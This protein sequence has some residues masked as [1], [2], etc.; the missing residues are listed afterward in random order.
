LVEVIHIFVVV[1]GASL[2]KFGFCM[3]DRFL[4]LQLF[5]RVARTGS[6]SIAGREMGMSQPTASRIVATLEKKVGVALLTRTTRG[7]TLTEA[8]SDY[9]VRAEAILAAL[10]EADHAARGTGELRGVLRVA[11][12]TSTAVR[13]ALPRLSRFTDLHPNLRIEFVL[14]DEKQDLVGDGIDVALRIGS[15]ADSSAIARKVGVVYRTLAAAPAYLAKAGT[16]RVPSDLANHSVIVGPAGRGMEGWAFKKDGKASSVRV[17]GRFVL[18]AA[19]G[20]TAAAVAGLGI[21]SNGALGM[22]KELES[23]LLVRV[24]PDWEMGTAEAHVILAAGHAAK[25]S[26]KAFSDFASSQFRELEA[27]WDRIKRLAPIPATSLAVD[28][29]AAVG[30]DSQGTA[31][32]R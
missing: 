11:M 27:A 31:A 29:F 8:G 3:N 10:D 26:A 21:V 23:G 22:L 24:L 5:T 4:S 32:D 2:N 7:V 16:P 14:N 12:S 19:E 9:L 13:F 17:E 1:R 30:G 25:P 28:D 6:F 18:N 15:L 20:A